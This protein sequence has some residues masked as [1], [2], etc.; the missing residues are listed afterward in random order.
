[1]GSHLNPGDMTLNYKRIKII[2]NYTEIQY[3]VCGGY[4]ALCFRVHTHPLL[5]TGM[6][7]C[8]TI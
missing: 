1:M 4:L 3:T 6:G 2:P 5:N 8:A 7:L